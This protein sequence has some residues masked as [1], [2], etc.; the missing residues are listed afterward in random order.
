MREHQEHAISMPVQAVK[1]H[2]KGNF[3]IAYEWAMLRKVIMNA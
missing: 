2:R 1:L 3:I